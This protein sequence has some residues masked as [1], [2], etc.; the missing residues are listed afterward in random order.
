MAGA[1]SLYQSLKE[2]MTLGPEHHRF[3]LLKPGNEHPLGQYWQAEDVSVTGNP[4]VTLLV[5]NPALLKQSAFVDGCKKFAALN[6][7]IQNKHIAACY[8]IFAHKGGLVFLSFE[9]LDGTTLSS[10]ISKNSLQEKQKLGLIKQLAYAI[11][12]GHQKLHQPHGCLEPDSVFIN[13]KGGVKLTRYAMRESLDTVQ[14]MLTNAMSYPAYQA[15]EAFRATKLNRKADVYAFAAIVYELLTGKAPF[16]LEDGEAER[17]RK[18]LDKPE[19]MEDEQ[20]Q[21][22]EKAFATDPEERF[23]SCTELVTAAFPN[24]PESEDQ[25]EEKAEGKTEEDATD[26][27]PQ[28]EEKPSLGARLKNMLPSL[29]K[30][31]RYISYTLSGL[32]IFVSGYLLGWF[33]SDFLNFKEKDFQALQIQKQQ[34]ALQQMFSSIQAQQELDKKRVADL[35]DKELDITILKQ[36]LLATQK[37]LRDS[38]PDQ[39][40]Q[41]V[42]KD[43]INEQFYGPEMVL[44]PSGE[45][46]MGDQSGRGDDNEKPVHIVHIDYTFALSRHEVTFADYDL[47][48]QETKRPLPDDNGWGRGNQPVINVTWEDANAYAEW[49]SDRTGHPYRL[50]TEA[51][52][53][54][55]ARGGTMTTYWWGNDLAENMAT[56]SG[57]GSQW[58]GKKPAPVGSFPANPWGLHDMTGNIDEWVADCYADSYN[59]VPIDG[60]AFKE[61][62]C[63]NRVMRGGSWFEIDRLIRPASRYRHPADAKRNSWGFR[64]ALDMK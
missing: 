62:A 24:K 18:V 11:D 6:K 29:P 36:Q 48:A 39:P 38:E 43:Q 63:K 9:K 61:R 42:F 33:I 16:R 1:D 19:S 57:C 58:D 40:G 4:I 15:P 41:Q 32:I 17:V 56:C 47:F 2:E 21:E 13:R 30:V 5:F 7:Q 35:E 8:G 20:W 60:S 22:L 34:E 25:A 10:V 54:Y 26:D 49:L 46:R 64:V 55:A 27:A 44:L 37:K 12:M 52:W 23:A 14:A 59:L 50:P 51:E 3:K 53:E 31:P 28:E 45:F